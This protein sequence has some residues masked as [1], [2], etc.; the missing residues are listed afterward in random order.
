[1]IEDVRRK[2][3]VEAG[4]IVV[5]TP[6]GDMHTVWK[7]NDQQMAMAAA[8]LLYLAVQNQNGVG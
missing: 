7:C 4:C 8:R 1:M 2:W 5:F 6:E 3:K